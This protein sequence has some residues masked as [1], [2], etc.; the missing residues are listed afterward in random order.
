[1][2]VFKEH[3]EGRERN[4]ERKKQGECMREAEN[5]GC[6]K[7]SREAFKNFYAQIKVL[8]AY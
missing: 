4:E 6:N 1:M 2:D 8:N 7:E 5:T 3:R